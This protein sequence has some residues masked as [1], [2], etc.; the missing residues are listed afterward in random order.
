[1]FFLIMGVENTFIDTNLKNSKEIKMKR[2]LLLQNWLTQQNLLILEKK[3]PMTNMKQR[4][5]DILY[6]Y[7]K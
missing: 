5:Q 7:L 3:L 4:N 2:K 6:L 1:M